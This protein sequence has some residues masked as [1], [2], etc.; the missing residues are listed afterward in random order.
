MVWE[1][2]THLPRFP[3]DVPITPMVSNFVNHELAQKRHARTVQPWVVSATLVRDLSRKGQKKRKKKKERKKKRKMKEKVRDQKEY[4]KEV[5][6][7]IIE[8]KT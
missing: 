8:P 3:E 4:R 5:M 7:R 1:V 6:E 2:A